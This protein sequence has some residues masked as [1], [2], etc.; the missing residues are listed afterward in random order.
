MLKFKIKRATRSQL[1]TAASSNNLEQGEPYLITDEGRIAVGLGVDSYEDF[2]KL[3]ESGGGG[4]SQSIDYGTTITAAANLSRANQNFKTTLFDNSTA[5]NLT[6]LLSDWEVG[7][8]FV[9]RQFGD[10]RATIV[11]QNSNVKLP[12]WN[13]T[14][15]KGY[16]MYIECYSISGSDKFFHIT[17]GTL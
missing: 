16:D 3:S 12:A 1:D 17:G 4:G 14:I 15:G 13:K 6:L 9:I 7:D 11:A 8:W 10:G 2:A 5:T